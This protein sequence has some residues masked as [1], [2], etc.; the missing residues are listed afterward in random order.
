MDGCH[1]N[2]SEYFYNWESDR[3]KVSDNA[4]DKI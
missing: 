2:I 1:S 3:Q 4:N